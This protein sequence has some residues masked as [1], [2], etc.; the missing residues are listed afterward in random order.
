M[1]K[2]APVGLLTVNKSSRQITWRHPGGKLRRIG[3][4]SLSD[5]ELLAVI[6]GSGSHGRSA[7]SIAAEIIDKYHSLS[8]LMG[9]PIGEI[10]HV[11]GMKEVKATKLAAVFEVARRIVRTLEKA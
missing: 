9:R 10:M 4:Y 3:A 6:I 7:Q 1:N 8:G 5:K 11:K 2:S